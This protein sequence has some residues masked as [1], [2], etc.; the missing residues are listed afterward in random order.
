MYA[1]L[2]LGY[3]DGYCAPEP[4]NSLAVQ[5]GEGVCVAT[6]PELLPMRPETVL[7]VRQSFAVGASDKHNAIIRVMMESCSFADQPENRPELAEI[8]SQSGYVNAPYSCLAAGLLGTFS[9]GYE[10]DGVGPEIQFNRDNVNKP[11]DENAR[12]L[13]QEVYEALNLDDSQR[14]SRDR[15]PILKNVFRR[16]IF[17]R[18]LTAGGVERE[19]AEI[20][21]AAAPVLAR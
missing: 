1:T 12:W 20:S 3:I 18:A 14:N 4:W 19:G 7:V 11:T 2:K 15:P 21:T 13:M 8:L 10:R 17:E 6:S 16:D 5:A 9:F